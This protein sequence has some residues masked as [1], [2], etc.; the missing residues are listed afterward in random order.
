ME[1]PKSWHG[2]PAFAASFL[3]FVYSL[4]KRKVEIRWKTEHLVWNPKNERLFLA[5]IHPV[6]T[7][8]ED[9]NHHLVFLSNFSSQSVGA[10]HEL[11]RLLRKWVRR[12]EDQ[13]SGCIQDLYASFQPELQQTVLNYEWLYSRELELVAGLYRLAE[14]GK[15]RSIFIRGEAGEGKSTLIHQLYC[16]LLSR[17]AS[18]IYFAPQKEERTFHS[19]K[20]LLRA[21]HEVSR[22]APSIPQD[23]NE[24]VVVKYFEKVFSNSRDVNALLIDNFHH[25]DSFSRRIL[26]RVFQQ[27]ANWKALFLVTSDSTYV[28]SSDTAVNLSLQKPSLRQLEEAVCIPLWKEKQRKQ[29]FSTIYERTSGNP[30]FFAEFLQEAFRSRKGS[31]QWNTNE[32][33]LIPPDVPDFPAALLEFY[34]N[35]KPDLS[36]AELAFLEVA[37]LKGEA[38][39]VTSEEEAVVQQLLEKQVLVENDGTFRF[40]KPLLAEVFRKRLPPERVQAI[41]QDLARQLSIHVEADS[42]LLLAQHFLKAGEPSSA[43]K[44]TCRAVEQLG[45]VIEPAALSLLSELERHERNL[46]PDEKIL[47]FRK[48]GEIYRRRGKFQHATVS[49]RRAIECGHKKSALHVD[50][51]LSIAEC[52]ILQEDILAAQNALHSLVPLL[53]TVNDHSL[54]FRYHI[55]RGVCSHYRGPRDAD[56]FRKAF[57]YAEE[58]ADD[59]LLAHGYQRSAWLSVREGQLG[60][61]SKLVKKSMRF[62]RMAHNSE[63]L[64]HCYKILASIAWRRSRLDHAEKMMKKSIRAF[65]KTQNA[66]GCAGVW[67][68]LG[69]VYL[70]KY[71]F[72]EALHSFEKA[73]GLF[74]NLEHSR[75]VSLAQFNMGLVY[76][77][78]GKL[79]QAEK[80]FLRCRSIDRASGNKWF[81]AYDLRALAVFCILQGYPRKATRLLNRTIEICEE[82]RADGDIL[83]T[84]MILMYHHLDQKNFREA[85]PLVS[86]LEERIDHSNEPLTLAEIHHLLAYYYGS[87]N[88]LD[89]AQVH[90]RKSLSISRRIQH[91]KLTGKNLIL[92]IIFRG[93]VLKRNDAEFRKAISNFKKSKNHLEFADYLL[94]LYQSYPELAKEKA[95]L[96]RLRWME[97]LYRSLHIKLRY[98]ATRR[99]TRERT[100]SGS[101]QVVYGWWQSLLASLSSSQDFESKLS[102]VLKDL[103][104]EMGSSYCQ[105][106]YVG[107][108][109]TFETIRMNNGSPVTSGRTEELAF[110]I[111]EQ[112]MRRREGMCLNAQLEPDVGSH[113]WTVLNDVGSVLATPVFKGDELFG[114]WYFERQKDVPVFT[115]EDLQKISF[116]STACA[117]LL[118]KAI[119]Q[120]AKRRLDSDSPRFL[121]DMVGAS[122]AVVEM[123]KLVEKVASVDVSVLIVGES[124]TGKELIARNIHRW[125]KRAAGPFVALNCSAIPETLIESELFGHTRGAFTG[126]V[127]ARAGSIEQANRGTL[128]LDEIGDLS[129]AAQAK[130]LRVIQ[131]REV[132][133]V[134]EATVRKVDVRFLFATHKNL[135]RMVKDGTYR[136]DLYYRIAGYTLQVPPLRDRKEDIPLLVRHF[137]EKFGHEFGKE[138]VR[139]SSAALR[140]L[141]DYFWPGNIR[142]M[143]NLIQSLLVN[144]DPESTIDA[145]ELPRSLKAHQ[146]RASASGMSLEE[147]RE[148]FDREFVLQALVR[149]DWNK[150]RAAKELKITRQGLINMI[151]RLRLQND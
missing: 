114:I 91:F 63:E 74:G 16:D 136:E 54:R 50:L 7:P 120:S 45:H 21:V 44:W 107:N 52:H 35:N 112:V 115:I 81:Y 51:S 47:L 102:K 1:R 53:P 60:E 12:K 78:I 119:E 67:N 113:P 106:R 85:Q 41:H 43:L 138:S 15:G 111:F 94:K 108:S 75:E 126:A 57:D 10:T 61:A 31:V 29:F 140:V 145:D 27:A 122:R 104:R 109:G 100:P 139:F 42:Y 48:Q 118:E 110:T 124:G 84:K 14:Q 46:N 128:F 147:G 65:Q 127:S 144:A 83:Q 55:A 134:G 79:K 123:S 77:E 146:I 95:H 2:L 4:Q 66:Y 39:Q 141:S 82:L 142:E 89:K 93:S 59:G 143:E 121:D 26:A 64:G 98:L 17:S 131:E 105:L 132:Q 86:Y 32:W 23:M 58:L 88:E 3:A 87:L 20:N 137:T 130:L 73:V 97:S 129:A 34:W 149:N 80:I 148:L 71:R 24:D 5:G 99:I 151:Q 56:E 62:A 117:P 8:H 33:T 69:N 76:L 103:S 6:K 38:F 116:F 18:T 125:S 19:M 49:F 36:Q 25:C 101:K 22:G 68:L 92:S 70:E 133:R 37:S 72:N 150:S 13:L 96:K 90:L 11:T 9:P 40:A 135:E 30:L 28:E